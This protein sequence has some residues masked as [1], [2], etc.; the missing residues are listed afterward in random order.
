MKKVR[1]LNRK[2]SIL[3]SPKAIAKPRDVV[4]EVVVVFTKTFLT[5]NFSKLD[6]GSRKVLFGE[7]RMKL[8]LQSQAKGTVNFNFGIDLRNN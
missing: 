5:E 2:Y 8:A 7:G 4:V 6:H 3:F 1:N